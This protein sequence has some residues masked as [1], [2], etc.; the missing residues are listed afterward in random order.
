[1]RGFTQSLNASLLGLQEVQAFPPF[2][3]SEVFLAGTLAFSYIWPWLS[4][5]FELLSCCY[6]TNVQ[7]R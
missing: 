4:Y 3:H 6:R 2:N 1:M 5:P 7:E